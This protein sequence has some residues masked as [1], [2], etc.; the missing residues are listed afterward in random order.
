[1][2]FN[3]KIT[4]LDYFIF[5]YEMNVSQYH[6]FAMNRNPTY[7]RNLVSIIIIFYFIP[8]F[9]KKMNQNTTYLQ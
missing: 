6:L 2:K 3:G 4:I 1:M 8:T 7:K 9:I 5:S